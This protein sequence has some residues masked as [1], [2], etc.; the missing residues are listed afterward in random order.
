M[1][2]NFAKLMR[3]INQIDNNS[4]SEEEQ[5]DLDMGQEISQPEEVS[6]D[7]EE[8][9]PFDMSEL[10][11]S[12]NIEIE[13]PIVD[14]NIQDELE[15]H[16]EEQKQ[17]KEILCWRDTINFI[18]TAKSLSEFLAEVLFNPEKWVGSVPEYEDYTSNGLYHIL[19]MTGDGLI[20]TLEYVNL[21]NEIVYVTLTL[22]NDGVNV[23]K[24]EK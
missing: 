2:A 15:S 18:N 5:Y 14:G 13:E 4:K 20:V 3:L 24:V 1:D 7:I 11:D 23:V 6:L 16:E 12:D 19:G 17:K 8:I 10:D 21:D 9:E 22:S